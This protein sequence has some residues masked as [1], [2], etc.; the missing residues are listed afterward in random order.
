MKVSARGGGRRPV[1]P[2]CPVAGS[3][4]GLGIKSGRFV[5]RGAVGRSC[6]PVPCPIHCLIP[7]PDAGAGR[8]LFSGPLL[9]PRARAFQRRESRP[10][11]AS[12]KKSKKFK[13]VVDSCR[14]RRLYTP[15]QR[16]RHTLLTTESFVSEF[17]ESWSKFKRAARATLD[18]AEAKSDTAQDTAFAVSVL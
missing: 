4:S 9:G 7:G 12:E 2:G 3:T 8:R 1:R 17:R 6:G 16:R 13:I 5:S 14:G 11:P 18:R 15:H 10:K